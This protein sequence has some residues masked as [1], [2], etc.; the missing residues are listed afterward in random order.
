MAV[1][2][3]FAAN[4]RFG[5]PASPAVG[6]ASSSADFLADRVH[7]KAPPIAYSADGAPRKQRQLI[8]AFDV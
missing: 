8:P 1:A 2:A 5:S 7:V 3:E 6:N 4:F